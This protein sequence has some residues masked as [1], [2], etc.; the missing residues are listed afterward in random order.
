MAAAYNYRIEIFALSKE[1]GG[2]FLAIAHDLAKMALEQTDS[3]RARKRS[4]K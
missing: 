3:E 2:G 1:D 4:K